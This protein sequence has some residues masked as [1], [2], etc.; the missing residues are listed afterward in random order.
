MNWFAT[1]V[2]QLLGNLYYEKRWRALGLFH[3][4]EKRAEGNLSA[5]FEYVKK[6]LH[7]WIE[8]KQQVKFSVMR[9]SLV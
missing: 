7:T 6:P 5:I 2:S 3:L 4:K 9:F 8:M 1:G